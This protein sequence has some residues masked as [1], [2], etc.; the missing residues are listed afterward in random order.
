M[1]TINRPKRQRAGDR[2]T[3][4]GASASEISCDHAVAPFDRVA[5]EME[6]AWGIEKLPELVSPATAAKY[7][8][9]MAKLNASIAAGSPEECATRAAVCIRGLKAMDAEARASGHQA[10]PD[11]FW[12]HEQNGDTIIIARDVRDWKAIE[13]MHPGVA[14]F[15]MTEVANALEA[16]GKT[17][18][19]V[20]REFAGSKIAAS[21]KFEGDGDMDGGIPF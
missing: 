14:I 15:S 18:M 2:L 19:A 5:R 1:A 7:G 20:K 12:L 11:G 4:P 16:Y 13:A 21:K 9:A 3:N 8:S 17:V 10:T 6:Q